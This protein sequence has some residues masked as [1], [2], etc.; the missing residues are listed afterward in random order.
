MRS[1]VRAAVLGLVLGMVCWPVPARAAAF[2]NPW[3]GLVF[4][5]DQAATG[6][7]TFG[8][9]FGDAGHALVGTETT[10]GFA[11]GIFG[12]ATGNYV[13]DLM[14]GFTI[15]KTFKSKTEHDT[16]PYG[17]IEGGTI[18]TSINGIG[19]GTDL[20]RNTI[21]LA[22][23]GG[24]TVAFNDRLLIK[25]ELRYIRSFQSHD[26]A[27]SL[28]VNLQDFHYWRTEFGIVIH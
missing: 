12:S 14:G 6:F 16:R 10:V 9:T 22:V 28:N 15:G 19:T 23:G 11:P 3:G 7:H 2:I 8:F 20:I 1:G 18:R 21:G 27:N 26:A 13:L 25:G 4:G 17:L 24:T 5:N